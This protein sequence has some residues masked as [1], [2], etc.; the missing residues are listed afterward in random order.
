MNARYRKTL[1]A[2]FSSP[3]PASIVYADIEALIVAL[4][5]SVSEREASRVKRGDQR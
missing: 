4:G 2:V 1:A 5:G 3:T